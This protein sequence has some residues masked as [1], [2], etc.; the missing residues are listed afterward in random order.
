MAVLG[1]P[2]LPAIP[3]GYV[4]LAERQRWPSGRPEGYP[5]PLRKERLVSYAWTADVPSKGDADG[6]G[7]R[8][9]QVVRDPHVPARCTPSRSGTFYTAF[10]FN[11][12]LEA[13]DVQGGWVRV[14]AAELR[15]RRFPTT[16]E[17][18]VLIDGSVA[19]V[20]R[21][22]KPVAPPPQEMLESARGAI[23][24]TDTGS[25]QAPSLTEPLDSNKL[26]TDPMMVA[27]VVAENDKAWELLQ[28]RLR[29]IREDTDKAFSMHHGFLSLGS[30][31]MTATMTVTEAQVKCAS[32]SH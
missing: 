32:L 18:W 9:F 24:L 17:V 23:F 1:T 6:P 21:L 10:S 29:L 4:N 3:G 27:K 11:E 28:A 8:W 22:L 25:P 7:P 20:G 5:E 19:G 31:I 14:S 30:D 12:V 2:S 16:D 26:G 15:R 13:S